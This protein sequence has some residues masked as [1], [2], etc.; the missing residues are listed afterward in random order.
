MKTQA[1]KIVVSEPDKVAPAQFVFPGDHSDV[2]SGFVASVDGEEAIFVLFD[3]VDL[4]ENAT[5]LAESLDDEIIRILLRGAVKANPKM[6]QEWN[7]LIA[8]HVPEDM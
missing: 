3:S 8:E 2:V 7:E 4:P 1:Y 6:V 5:Q